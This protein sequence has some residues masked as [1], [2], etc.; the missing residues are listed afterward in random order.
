MR[1]IIILLL[2]VVLT[3]LVLWAADHRT[4]VRLTTDKGDILIE[5]YNET[6][7]HRDNFIKLC[8][9]HFYDSLIFHRVIAGFMIQTGDP[10]SK[11]AD[12]NIPLGDGGPGYDLPA[13][14][15][16]PQFFHKRGALAAAR[17]SDSTNPDRR[18]SGSQFY[19]VWGKRISN[20]ELDDIATSVKLNTGQNLSWPDSIRLIYRKQGGT[21]Y[22][23]GQYSVFGEVVEGLDVVNKIQKAV[24]VDNDRPYHDVV[25]LKTEVV[26]A[27]H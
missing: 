25:I 17:E 14:I 11:G 8:Q 4:S 23:D 6:P 9:N 12:L 27:S 3:S 13:E 1:L 21:P 20:N 15:R 2:S 22:L 18:S 24:T 16:F 26:H 10:K 19:I 7:R 5:L